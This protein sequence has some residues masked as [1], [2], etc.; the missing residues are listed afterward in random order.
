MLSLKI[1]LKLYISINNG[2]KPYMCNQCDK[3][4]MWSE[5]L[6]NICLYIYVNNFSL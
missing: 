2:E 1:I 5:P 6:Q 3:D 4:S